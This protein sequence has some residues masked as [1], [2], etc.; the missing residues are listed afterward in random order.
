[1][2]A[3]KA[4]RARRFSVFNYFSEGFP[5]FLVGG[6]ANDFSVTPPP[7]FSSVL[8]QLFASFPRFFLDISSAGL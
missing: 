5:E 4:L 1:M 6:F 3:R 7:S 2:R 8:R